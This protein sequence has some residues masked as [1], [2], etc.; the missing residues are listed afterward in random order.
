MSGILELIST[1]AYS[2]ATLVAVAAWFASL[3]YGF[4]TVK[5]RKS[6]VRLWGEETLWNP[7]NVLLRPSLLTD[8][9]LIC[10]R[11]CFVSA[12]IFVLTIGVFMIVGALT[13][14]LN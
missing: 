12:L 7:A 3:A 9:G 14:N 6:G 5:S 1:A 10:R 4:K 13:G 8:E 2:I 11:R